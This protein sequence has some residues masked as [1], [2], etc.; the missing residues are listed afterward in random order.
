MPNAIIDKVVKETNIPK[1]KVEELWEQ[2]KEIVES[3]YKK[4][5][6]IHRA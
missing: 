1:E 4:T 6:S 5:V 2:A 3:Q